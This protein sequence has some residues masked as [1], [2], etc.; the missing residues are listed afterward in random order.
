M[1]VTS[2]TRKKYEGGTIDDRYVRRYVIWFQSVSN[3]PLDG[4]GTILAQS[5]D[6]WTGLTLL[7][8]IGTPYSEANGF[9]DL[10]AL[11]VLVD[12]Q[13]APTVGERLNWMIRAEFASRGRDP[14]Q[15]IENPLLRPAIVRWD[16]AEYMRPV[17]VALARVS[18]DNPDGG[19]EIEEGVPPR[20][21]SEE[22]FIPPIEAEDSHRV[23]T[24][25]RNQASFDNAL[26]ESFQ[27][28]VNDAQFS[29]RGNVIDIGKSKCKSVTGEEVY[30][31]GFLY[32]RV[33][34]TIH[35]R[36]DGWIVSK[37]DEGFHEI[38][39]AN[40]VKI[41]YSDGTTPVSVAQ[42]LNG[43]GVKLAVGAA[44]VFRNYRIYDWADHALLGFPP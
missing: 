12:P 44:P 18:S 8:T 6:P 21:S 37:L 35:L 24:M 3:N 20:S 9:T 33:T 27:D 36:R 40:R 26:A 10:G 2:T 22:R 16:A 28:T 38:S 42:P 39:G 5:I 17:E 32:Y 31:N 19:N 30:E 14:A 43:S 13:A 29:I 11:C 34:T 1:T 4:P 25:E 41:T 23:V 7:A 15:A